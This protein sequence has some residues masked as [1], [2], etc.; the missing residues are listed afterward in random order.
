MSLAMR[1]L[2]NF[3]AVR[4]SFL[5]RTDPH[6]PPFCRAPDAFF[7]YPEL[8]AH[9]CPDCKCKFSCRYDGSK[10]AELHKQQLQ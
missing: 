10:Q 8:F 1:I 7:Q 5:V 3:L 4:Q 6:V 9:D 2:T